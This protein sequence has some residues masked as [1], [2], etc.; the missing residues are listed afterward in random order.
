[1]YGTI[2]SSF[3]ISFLPC[4]K[5]SVAMTAT[6]QF[7]QWLADGSTILQLCMHR[8]GLQYSFPSTNSRHIKFQKHLFKFN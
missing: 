3:F 8:L 2:K 4:P 6:A 1:M 7:A 5:L